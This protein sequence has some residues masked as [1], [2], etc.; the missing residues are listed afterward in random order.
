MEERENELLMVREQLKFANDLGAKI[1]R[2]FAV[3]I[4]TLDPIGG[5]DLPP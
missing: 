5:Q 2:V 4:G 3:W 1:M